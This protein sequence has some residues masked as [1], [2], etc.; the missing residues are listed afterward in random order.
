MLSKTL[1]TSAGKLL[2]PLGKGLGKIGIRPNHIT[3]MGLILTF[4]AS[5]LLY[6]QNI[7]YAFLL[8]L[9]ASL[10]DGADGLVARAT[11]TTSVRG[12]YLD[13]TLDRYADCIAFS[14]LILCDWVNPLPIGSLDFISGQAWAMAA[15][16]GAFQTSYCRA[17]AERL[18]VSQEGIGLIERP[19]RWFILGMGLLVGEMMNDVGTIIT[20]VVATLAILGNLTALQRMNHFWNEA[21]DE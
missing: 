3:I 17:A 7:Y 13:A 10:F 19:E 11:K 4:Y 9:I 12:G 15:M 16:I 20:I 1:K 2:D 18:G 8:G 21:K 6:N 5:F 14:A